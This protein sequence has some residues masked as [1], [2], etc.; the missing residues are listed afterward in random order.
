[1]NIYEHNN[2]HTYGC[3]YIEPLAMVNNYQ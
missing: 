2:T 1:M 3:L